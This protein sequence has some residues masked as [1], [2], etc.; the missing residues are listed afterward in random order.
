MESD[1]L[2]LGVE[3]TDPSTLSAATFFVRFCEGALSGVALLPCGWLGDGV[4][5]DSA[6][7]SLNDFVTALAALDLGTSV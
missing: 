1:Y 3:P 7:W 6:S 2:A 4:L 5:R